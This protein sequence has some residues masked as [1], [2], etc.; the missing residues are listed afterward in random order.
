MERRKGNLY[1]HG[2]TF[3]YCV[4]NNLKNY[5]FGVTH[6]L[7]DNPSHVCTINDSKKYIH[8]PGIPLVDLQFSLSLGTLKEGVRLYAVSL[9]EKM[10]S[11][12]ILAIYPVSLSAVLVTKMS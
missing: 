9:E 1:S 3:I 10:L 12:P 8:F 5:C 6:A 7:V 4:L 2:E 11:T